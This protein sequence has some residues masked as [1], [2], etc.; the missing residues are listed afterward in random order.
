[1]AILLLRRDAARDV[2]VLTAS[3][4]QRAS[5]L[6]PDDVDRARRR[7]S[8]CSASLAD[9]RCMRLGSSLEARPGAAALELVSTPGEQG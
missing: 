8:S 1:M 6:L 2:A 7:V 5:L 9:R 4:D 3:R